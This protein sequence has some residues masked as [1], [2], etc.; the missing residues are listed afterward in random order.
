MDLP[1]GDNLS[2][3][4]L[5]ELR[6]VKVK[7]LY[8]NRYRLEVAVAV[9]RATDPFY[10]H[11]IATATGVDDS[12]VRAILSDM[13]AAGLL[14]RIAGKRGAPKFYERTSK[15]EYWTAAEAMLAELLAT[16]P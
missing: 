3:E 2:P 7:K 16:V 10:L 5:D 1:L 8:G 11:E 4:A 12:P 15:S 14:R 6:D 13:V 9:A